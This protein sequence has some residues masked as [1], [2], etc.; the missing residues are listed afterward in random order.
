[1]SYLLQL[2]L[3]EARQALPYNLTAIL[4][5]AS[6]FTNMANIINP[7]DMSLLSAVECNVLLL[8]VRQ[9][10]ICGHVQ[11]H[12]IVT[13]LTN[14]CHGVIDCVCNLCDTSAREGHWSILAVLSKNGR[15]NALTTMNTQQGLTNL[16]QI[17]AVAAAIKDRD[18]RKSGILETAL[19]CW[20]EVGQAHE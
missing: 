2:L 15:A 5:S 17:P 20:V 13:T 16:E 6:V 19:N 10:I 1:M 7:T 12:G 11:C 4:A 14:K 18:L 8:N 9:T 3:E